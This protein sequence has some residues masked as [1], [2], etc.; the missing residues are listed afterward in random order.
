MVVLPQEGLE[1]VHGQFADDPRGVD[2]YQQL[3]KDPVIGASAA[4]LQHLCLRDPPLPYSSRGH[5]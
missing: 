5:L 1:R 4:L 3:A 2:S